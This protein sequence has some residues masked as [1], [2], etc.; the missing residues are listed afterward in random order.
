[1]I[2]W[3]EE[4]SYIVTIKYQNTYVLVQ[5]LVTGFIIIVLYSI[6]TCKITITIRTSERQL[7]NNE[8]RIK[9]SK[10]LPSSFNDRTRKR[11]RIIIFEVFFELF[12]TVPKKNQ[13]ICFV[14]GKEREKNEET[15]P[16][17][18]SKIVVVNFSLLKL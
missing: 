5:L 1:M 13:R 4:R 16:G 14:E 18:F 15:Q 11:W 9:N 2:I 8:V 7:F 3:G 6:C 12:Q 10:F 17:N